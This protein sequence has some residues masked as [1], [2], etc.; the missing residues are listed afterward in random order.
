MQSRGIPQEKIG[1]IIAQSRL[2]GI[3]RSIGDAET[4]KLVRRALGEEVQEDA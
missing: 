2:S 4:E 1:G 3:L